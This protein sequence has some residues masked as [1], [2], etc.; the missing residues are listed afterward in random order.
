MKRPCNAT[1]LLCTLA[2]IFTTSALAQD[3]GH[4]HADTTEAMPMDHDGMMGM[5]NQQ[6]MQMHERMMADSVLHQRMMADPEMHTMMEEMMAGEMTMAAM[7]EQMQASSPG[8]RQVMM[9]QMHAGMM[10]RMEAMPPEQRE[11]MKMKMMEQHQKLM[12]DPEVRER[13]MADP[14]MRQMMEQ[15]EEGG[16]MDHDQMD[17]DRMEG[18]QHDQMDGMD[19]DTMGA[20]QHGAGAAPMSANEARATEQAASQVADRFHEALAASDRAAVEALLLPDV[21]VLE[22]GQ[23]ESRAE[24][25]SGHFASDAAFLAAVEREPLTRRTTVAGDAAWV[26]SSSRLSGTYEGEALDLD[27]A[28]LLVLRRDEAAPDG[29]RIAA[30]HWS[31][32]PRE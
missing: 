8:E 12:A 26:A 9:Q 10:E 31:S 1:L 28:E 4:Q 5:M 15:M 14:E 27:S 21:T 22:G 25:L 30:V 7:R 18:M 16:M 19:P 32:R 13:V 20:M 17:H 24:Y 11:A 6:M 3:H 29:W 2:L 23:A